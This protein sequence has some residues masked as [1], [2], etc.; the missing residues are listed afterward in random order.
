[1]R[2]ILLFIVFFSVTVFGQDL[3]KVYVLS[4]GGFAPNTSK[5]SIIDK[6]SGSFS[7][8]VFSPGNLGLVPDGLMLHENNL[9]ITEQGNYGGS[10]KIYKADT[11]G[12]VSA[13]AAA[14]V[15]P[16]S[17]SINNDKIFVTNGPAGKVTVLNLS[18]LSFR[19]EIT[20]GVY[21]QEILSIGKYVFVAN[22][23]L[24]GGSSD[25]TISVIDSETESVVKTINV[26]L[27]PSSLALSAD[28]MLLAGCPGDETG[29]IIYKINPVTFEKITSYTIPQYGFGSCINADTDGKKFYFLTYF[30][31]L[32]EYNLQTSTVTEI[33]NPEYGA[34][35]FYGY[36]YDNV[37]KMHYVLDAK[38]FASDGAVYVFDASGVLKNSYTA[39]I[40]PKRVVFKY[41]GTS[42]V[43][44]EEYADKSYR[45]MQN[46]PNPFNPA[47]T[48]EFSLPVSGNVKL[49]VYNLLGQEVAVLVNEFFSGGNHKV[50]FNASGLSSG[51]YLYQIQAGEFSAV[52]KLMLVK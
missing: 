12:A 51:V 7:P 10:G 6:K 8:S 17:L 9:Y 31:N 14:G 21:P 44:G 1:M 4:E 33:V 22:T 35:Y 38:D 45:L 27:N 5:L 15:N 36:N 40:A 19:K 3:S 18:D 23:S 20:V 41:N 42:S 25:S 50:K 49:S 13:S 46:Y 52:K 34:N 2:K 30:N 26:R 37:N 32:V 29:G 11:L 39:S 43:S 24:W 28:N 48:I 16:Y 47:T